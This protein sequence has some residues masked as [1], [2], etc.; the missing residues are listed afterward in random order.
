MED[1]EPGREYLFRYFEVPVGM[2]LDSR[3]TKQEVTKS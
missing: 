1:R 3:F 2:F